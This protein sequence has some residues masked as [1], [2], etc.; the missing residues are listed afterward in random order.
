M[1]DGGL[2]MRLSFKGPVIILS[3]CLVCLSVHAL[4]G[5]SSKANGQ[6]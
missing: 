3:V 4:T 5:N 1:E 6:L 2:Q